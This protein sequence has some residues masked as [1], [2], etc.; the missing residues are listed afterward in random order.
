MTWVPTARVEM[1]AVAATPETMATGEPTFAPSIWNWT[2]PLAVAGVTVAVKVTASE[3][4]DGLSE[5]ARASE[6]AALITTWPPVS[7]PV[8]VL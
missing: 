6:V 1:A 2:T 8:T 3:N 4:N 7:V 5:D